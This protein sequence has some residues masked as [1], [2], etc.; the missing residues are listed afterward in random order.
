MKKEYTIEQLANM[1]SFLALDILGINNNRWFDLVEYLDGDS[2]GFQT[3]LSI[4]SL[5]HAPSHAYKYYIERKSALY[6][7]ELLERAVKNRKRGEKDSFQ[8]SF[9]ARLKKRMAEQEGKPFKTMLQIC[10][11]VGVRPSRKTDI[12]QIKEHVIAVI[13]EIRKQTSNSVPIYK[14]RKVDGSFIELPADMT[15]PI[16]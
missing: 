7:E 10:D 13:W 14:L 4:H 5:Q 2:C 3:W 12:R 6:G 11:Y 1:P 15:Y 16:Y 9:Y 8:F